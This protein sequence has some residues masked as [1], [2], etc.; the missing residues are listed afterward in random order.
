MIISTH[1]IALAPQNNS[2]FLGFKSSRASF[3]ADEKNQMF[4]EIACLHL[5]K[6]FFQ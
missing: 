3:G 2:S 6:D 5:P 4:F 1:P